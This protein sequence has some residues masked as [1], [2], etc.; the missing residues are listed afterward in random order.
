MHQGKHRGGWSREHQNKSLSKAGTA[1]SR[2]WDSFITRRRSKLRADNASLQ[3]ESLLRWGQRVPLFLVQ[4]SS[5]RGTLNTPLK[6]PEDANSKHEQTHLCLAWDV[7]SVGQLFW[8]SGP[9]MRHT[10]PPPISEVHRAQ[11]EVQRSARRAAGV[12]SSAHAEETWARSAEIVC[13]S[14]IC[15]FYSPWTLLH[16]LSP[17]CFY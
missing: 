2:E 3:A 5:Q 10:C 15:C 17:F 8:T 4:C 9:Q 1:A 16:T 12:L 6:L 13:V 7:D 14:I 11:F